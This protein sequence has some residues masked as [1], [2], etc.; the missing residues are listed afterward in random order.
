MANS[1]PN[2]ECISIDTYRNFENGIKQVN[3]KFPKGTFWVRDKGDSEYWT[4]VPVEE[5]KHEYWSGPI[6]H[7]YVFDKWVVCYIRD[8]DHHKYFDDF[9]MSGESMMSIMGLEHRVFAFI[10]N[11]SELGGLVRFNKMTSFKGRASYIQL[12]SHGIV[13]DPMYG[14]YIDENARPSHLDSFGSGKWIEVDSKIA[15]KMWTDMHLWVLDKLNFIDRPCPLM[16]N[17]NQAYDMWMETLKTM[18]IT[19]SDSEIINKLDETLMQSMLL[20]IAD[21]GAQF[22]DKEVVAKIQRNA[23][24][25]NCDDDLIMD[26]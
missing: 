9:K 16:L 20:Q 17:C 24:Y 1:N 13:N 25:L 5:Y 6:N 8:I 18:S 4:I 10:K 12:L 23:K 26:E 3:I 7:E 22:F 14:L 19:R 2:I 15:H 21:F 11:S